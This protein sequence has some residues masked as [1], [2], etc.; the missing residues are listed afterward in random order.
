MARTDEY[1]AECV[2]LSVCLSVCMH[3]YRD[4]SRNETGLEATVSVSV[5]ADVSPSQYEMF[6]LR[7]NARTISAT[8]S[9]C[10]SKYWPRSPRFS[11]V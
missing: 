8:T 4:K 1:C 5:S 7:L 11:F 10:R 3:I 2:C 6:R 9:I